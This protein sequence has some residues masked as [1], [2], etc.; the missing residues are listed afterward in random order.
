M[1]NDVVAEHTLILC[2]KW[3]S[4]F[5]T[6]CRSNNPA[7]VHRIL[8]FSKKWES[9]IQ[10]QGK[11]P[12]AAASAYGAVAKSALER[13]GADTHRVMDRYKTGP[14][15]NDLVLWMEG[16]YRIQRL[17]KS[18][19]L[20]GVFYVER[21]LLNGARAIASRYRCAQ[22]NSSTLLE[23]AGGCRTARPAPRARKARS[24]PGGGFLA[25]TPQAL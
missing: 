9:C 2:A 7:V 8:P 14:H 23:C 22:K 13:A 17:V 4:L 12:R 18:Q 6:I 11:N 15:R 20:L 21:G 5:D 19:G 16:W 10:I 3:A 24:D 25:M 1:S